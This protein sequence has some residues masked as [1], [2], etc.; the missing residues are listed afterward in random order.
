MLLFLQISMASDD[1]RAEV[2][3][4]F[5]FYPS[6]A[7]SIVAL[8]LFILAS[9]T[10]LGMTIKTRQWY[11]VIASIVGFMEMGGYACR[12]QMLHKPIYGAYVAM[13]CLLIIPPSFLAL[14]QYITLGKVVALVKQRF[15]ERKLLVKPRLVIWGFFVMEIIALTCQ[16]AGAGLSVSDKGV[17][18]TLKSGRALLIVGLV[19]L[20]VLMLCYGIT[21]V[22]VNRSPLYD[23]KHSHNLRRLFPVLYVCTGLLLIR[24]IFRLVE[25]AQGFEGAIARQEKYFY[26]FDALMI[27][28]ILIVNTF[29]HFGIYL[30][31]YPTEAKAEAPSSSVEV[32]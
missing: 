28:L 1:V 32:V 22:Y 5:D 17:N 16:G 18:D 27:F 11:M 25:F 19:A 31:A 10:V 23:V 9:L 3:D 8:V 13:Q 15:P 6:M 26:G 2:I 14:V 12:I 21:A 20:V 30:K 29:F 24:N 7:L 4:Y